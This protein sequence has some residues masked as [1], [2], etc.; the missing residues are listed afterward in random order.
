MGMTADEIQMQKI[1]KDAKENAM[2][3][4]EAVKTDAETKNDTVKE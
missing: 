2:K 3:E 4:T 1:A